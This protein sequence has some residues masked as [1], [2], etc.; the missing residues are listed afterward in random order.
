MNQND[1]IK[2]IKDINDIIYAKILDRNI[3]SNLY[4]IIT[5]NIIHDS[6]DSKYMIN[7][8]YSKKYSRKFCDEMISNEDDYSIYQ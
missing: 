2:D 1:K 5:I 4:D 3:D 8:K 6:Y 7:E